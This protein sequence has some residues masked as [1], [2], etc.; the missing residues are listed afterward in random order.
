MTP[1]VAGASG[2]LA[3]PW[4]LEVPFSGPTHDRLLGRGAVRGLNRSAKC[5]YLRNGQRHMDDRIFHLPKLR[6]ALL[7]DERAA[8]RQAF[9]QF[10]L[11]DLRD[12]GPRMVRTL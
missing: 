6:D 11:Q 5:A 4:S 3:Q 9:R 12:R 7:R 8:F 2:Q 10:Q 1:R